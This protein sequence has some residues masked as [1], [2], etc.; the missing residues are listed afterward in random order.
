MTPSGYCESLI[1]KSDYDRY[2]AAL[3]APETVRGDLFALY[4][5][6]H[7]IAR[8]AGTVRNPVAGQ[9]RLQ[10]WRERLDEAF[11][12]QPARVEV[13]IALNSAV[14]RHRLP[15]PVFE[16]MIDAREFDLDPAP[17]GDVAAL[18]SYVDATSGN[19]MRLAAR[20]LGA[21]AGGD[22]VITQAGLAYG[23]AGLLRALPFH[24][25]RSHIAMP[26]S[27]MAAAGVT[28]DQI[29]AGQNS[30]K[31]AGLVRRICAVARSHYERIG[32]IERTSLP[33]ILPAAL[34]P[35]TLRVM[36]RPGFNP[37]RTPAE[38]PVYRRQWTMLRSVVSNQI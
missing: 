37:F 30:P 24:A 11:A 27:E 17:F 19:V 6:N 35:G 20:I 3:F 32:K 1:R 7:E 5:F 34:V 33:A 23:I 12:G 13:L 14:I 28:S 38:I 29:L 15:K 26:L 8:V 2:L 25:A 21:G 9:I 18:E 4:G 10:W 16:A 36:S 31:M 22:P